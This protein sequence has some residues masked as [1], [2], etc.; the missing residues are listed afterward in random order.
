MCQEPPEVDNPLLHMDEVI[1]TSPMAFYSA[2]ARQEL[3]RK[4]AQKL[5]RALSGELPDSIV[6]AEVLSRV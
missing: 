5:V 4:A 2:E 3:Q 1:M 6:N